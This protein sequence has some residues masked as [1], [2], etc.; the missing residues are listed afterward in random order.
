MFFRCVYDANGAHPDPKKVSA[1]HKMSAPGTATQLQK[2]L[3]LVSYLSPF[4]PSLSSFT[5]PL[6]EQLK[7]GTEFIWNNPYQEAFDKVKSMVCKDTTVWSFD[8]YKPA[9][10]QVDASQK[11]LGATLLQ[12]G[13]PVAFTSKALTPV[14]QCYANIEHELL[15]CVFGAE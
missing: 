11:G 7:T 10:V 12:G 4:I 15:A 6:H 1:V 5:V 3:R 2:F 14:E 9:T 8:V 13:C